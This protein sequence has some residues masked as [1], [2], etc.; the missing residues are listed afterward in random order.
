MTL[1]INLT[2]EELAALVRAAQSAGFCNLSAYLHYLM[3][4]GVQ[5]QLACKH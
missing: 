3:L 2:S 1:S 4:Q 5:S